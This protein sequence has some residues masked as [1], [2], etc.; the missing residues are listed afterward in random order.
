LKVERRTSIK[1]R[2]RSRVL[3]DEE[4]RS[5]WLAAEQGGLFGNYVRFLLLTATRRN[6]ALGL[7]RSELS[8][9]GTTWTIPAARYKQ[10]IDV[11]IPLS[12]AAQAIVAAQAN[13][14]DLVFSKTGL[15]ELGGM[16]WRKEALDTAAGVTGWTLHDLRRTARTLLSRAGINADVA[17]R[18]LGH[19]IQGVRGT[20]DRHSFE[21][22]KRHAFEA[23]AATVERI[24]HPPAD[25]V[26]PL[27]ALE[28]TK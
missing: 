9:D 7:R 18:C 26:V 8:K 3:N 21:A 2:A 17:E 6:E 23:L 16:Q 27:R 11:V 12:A 25:V 15:T 5:V 13:V 28:T 4:L 19:A 24:V 20:Y 1:E 14:G 22:E 10:K